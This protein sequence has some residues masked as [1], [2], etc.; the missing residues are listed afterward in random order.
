VALSGDWVPS[1]N[2]GRSDNKTAYFSQLSPG[3]SSIRESWGA[4]G[5]MRPSAMRA[6]CAERLLGTRTGPEIWPG[7]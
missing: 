5:K 1:S 2:L 7:R 6:A 4:S 3:K